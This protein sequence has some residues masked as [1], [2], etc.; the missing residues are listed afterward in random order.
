MVAVLAGNAPTTSC[1]RNCLIVQGCCHQ[2]C[3]AILVCSLSLP[4]LPCCCCPLSPQHVCKYACS[5]EVP[6]P[7]DVGGEGFCVAFDPLDGSSIVDTNFA[8]GTI[9]GVWPGDKL[10]GITGREQVGGTSGVQSCFG[11]G[12]GYEGWGRVLGCRG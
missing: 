10:K 3:T 7:V 11:L 5:E 4:V 12:L 6:E 8:V 9:F 2:L 1:T